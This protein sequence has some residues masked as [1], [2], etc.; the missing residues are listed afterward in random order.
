MSIATNISGHLRASLII[1][2]SVC[3]FLLNGRLSAQE[4]PPRPMSLSTFQNLSFGAFITGFMGGT[5]II[6]PDGT[7]S[8]TGDI[9]TVFQGYQH[10]P[11]IFE[12]EANPGVIISIMNGPDIS[13]NGSNGGTLTLHLGGSIPE[14]PFI[15]TLR[16]P[17]RTQVRIGGTL[18]VG[19]MLDNPAGEY[20]G[21]FSV[22]FIQE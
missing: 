19:N 18:I 17:F 12:V 22:T 1:S 5:V 20:S 2:I 21:T 3:I 11:A 10:H 7:R 16:P 13:L 8:V 14:S 9:I 4:E 6:Y 15:N